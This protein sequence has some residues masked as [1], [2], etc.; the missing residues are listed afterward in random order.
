ML[1][2]GEDGGRGTLAHFGLESERIVYMGTLGKAAGVAGAFVAAHPAVIET[3]R[4]DRALLHLHDGRAAVR[5]PRRFARASRSSRGDTAR[6]AH[7]FDL[8]ARFRERMRA[9]PWA[10][11]DSQTPIQ[12]IVVG[13]NAA[14]VELA[15]ALW[16]RGF[17]VPA[18]RP[19]TVP[20]GTARLRITLT[21]AHTRDD[22]DALVDALADLAP[23]SLTPGRSATPNRA[24]E[25]RCTSTRPGKVRRSCCCT[26][27]RCIRGIWGPLVPRLARRYRVHAVD[28]PGHG[29]SAAPAE[30]TLD[31]VVAA[32]ASAFAAEGAAAHG[33]GLVAGRTGRDAL[34]ARPARSE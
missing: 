15:G 4:A 27:G 26:A 23:R 20:S 14:A 16:D 28:L 12:P 2:E 17:W 24:S 33:A 1:G 3:L 18:I 21:A 9:L 29:H 7:L 8:V 25:C 11:R 32:L 6:R 5:S 13:A 30:F 31:G 22:V 10:L 19:P 34:G